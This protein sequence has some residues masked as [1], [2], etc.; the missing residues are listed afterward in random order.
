MRQRGVP[1]H[2]AASARD[3]GIGQSRPSTPRR[4]W[5][6]KQ[7]RSPS[8]SCEA[9]IARVSRTHSAR[10]GYVPSDSG[11]GRLKLAD[12]LVRLD[13]GSDNSREGVMA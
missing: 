12:Q 8:G 4:A 6:P 10:R 7:T 13:F 2:M 1:P 3:R 9:L 11:L 5:P